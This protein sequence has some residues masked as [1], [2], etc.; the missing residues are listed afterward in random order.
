MINLE[1]IKAMTWGLAVADAVGVP[2]EFKSRESLKRKPV[3]DMF[4]FGSHY[5][6][7]GTWSD[8]TSMTIAT[9]ESISR[10]GRIDYVDLMNNFAQWYFEGEFTA[11]GEVFD[12]GGTTLS[13]IIK[14]IKKVPLEECGSEESYS[15]GNGSLMRILPVAVYLHSIYG[16]NFDDR[17]MSVIHEVSALTHAHPRS[18]VGCGIYSLIAVQLLKGKPILES[19]QAGLTQAKEFYADSAFEVEVQSYSRLWRKD[20][21]NL[22]EVEIKSTGYVVDTLEAALWCLLNTE[23][24][25]SLVLKAVNLGDDTDTVASVAG[26]L[27]GIYYGLEEIPKEW[28]SKL[29]RREYLEEIAT[30]FF[31]SC[32]LSEIKQ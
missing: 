24:Y 20:F 18:L 29:Q 17:A 16:D 14:Y 8:D 23:D 1:K 3:T 10:L 25:K 22:L 13:A 11:T 27:A 6:P 5:Q 4:G 26:G 9:M 31:H 2:V 15:N 30:D 28:L 21:A 19:I 12:C 32:G 7:T